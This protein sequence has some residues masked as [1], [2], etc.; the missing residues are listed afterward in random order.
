MAGTERKFASHLE[1]GE[2]EAK[3][4]QHH[5]RPR[6]A[7]SPL[8]PKDFIPL[9]ASEEERLYYGF[10][11]RPNPATHPKLHQVWERN[12]GLPI[13]I[14]H[15]VPR[16]PPELPFLEQTSN[17]ALKPMFQPLPSGP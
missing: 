10:P 7:D 17:T 5:R 12:L 6:H 1:D 13:E 3:K 15:Q 11:A 9:K 14:R 4:P 8:P 16:N 2:D